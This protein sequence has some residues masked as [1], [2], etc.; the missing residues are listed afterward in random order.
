[1]NNAHFQKQV[2]RLKSQ[3]PHGFGEEKQALIWNAFQ[4]VSDQVF[5]EAV[6][7]TIGNHRGGAP[8]ISDLER[9]VEV[10]KTREN[11]ARFNRPHGFG[12][13]V[14]EAARINVRADK[15]FVEACAKHL[16]LFQTGKIKRAQFDSG[17]DDLDKLA[18]LLNPPGK[19]KGYIVNP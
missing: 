13:E 16:K 18:D 4:A 1:M 7:E 12:T 6:S 15:D 17:C 9:A 10:A 11:G 3:W 8:I 2:A 5:S 14:A 19:A